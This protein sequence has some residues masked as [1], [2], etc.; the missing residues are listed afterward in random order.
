MNHR[1]Q[2]SNNDRRDAVWYAYG[3]K[4]SERAVHLTGTAR[5]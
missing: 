4:G 5:P 1:W 3:L 2:L